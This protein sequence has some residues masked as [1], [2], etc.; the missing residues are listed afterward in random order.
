MSEYNFQVLDNVEKLPGIYVEKNGELV[1]WD[2][3]D[4]EKVIVLERWTVRDLKKHYP[5]EY[6]K[7]KQ[8]LR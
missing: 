6:K 7:I 4:V 2:G 3:S 5:K 1:A 8:E